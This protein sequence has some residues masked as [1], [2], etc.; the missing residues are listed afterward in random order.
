MQ[1][2]DE[3]VKCNEEAAGVA[4]GSVVVACASVTDCINAGAATMLLLLGFCKGCKTVWA[5][6]TAFRPRL[7]LAL[8]TETPLLP[9]DAGKRF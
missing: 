1:P 6:A 7:P 4:A 5:A 2:G 9:A 8:T 3:G